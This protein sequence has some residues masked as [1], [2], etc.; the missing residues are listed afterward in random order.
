[1]FYFPASDHMMLFREFA[2]CLFINSAY[3]CTWM[4]VLQ[5]TFERDS[6][7]CVKWENK[8]YK[9]KRSI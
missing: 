8:T 2:F 5:T 6:S 7:P 4:H 9:L 3:I 1:M